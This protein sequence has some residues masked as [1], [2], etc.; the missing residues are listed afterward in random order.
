MQKPQVMAIIM[1]SSDL[2]EE[3]SPEVE[4]PFAITC[5]SPRGAAA[6]RTRAGHR[7]YEARTDK[8]DPRFTGK[9]N[10][11]QSESV[12]QNSAC[13]RMLLRLLSK[14]AAP[15]NARPRAM[16]QYAAIT[17]LEA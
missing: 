2:E 5:F 14:N 15:G 17:G 7:N 12:P 4:L 1:K 10:A 13:P 6:P 11:C 16:Q 8:N 9:S 3:A